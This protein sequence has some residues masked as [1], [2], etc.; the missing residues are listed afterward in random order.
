MLA[1]GHL[2]CV[3][4]RPLGLAQD[5]VCWPERGVEAAATV[6]GDAATPA[7]DAD[8]KGK[9]DSR[10]V[11]RCQGLG[12][13]LAAARDYIVFGSTRQHRELRTIA[14]RTPARTD[15]GDQKRA[16]DTSAVPDAAGLR[17]TGWGAH[18]ERVS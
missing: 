7:P 4:G 2:T 8:G 16:T 11:D 3:G 6:G 14:V 9:R 5:C 12:S 17:A 13:G 15:R 10:P 18:A 1:A